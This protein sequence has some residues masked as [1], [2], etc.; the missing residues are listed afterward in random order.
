ML[1]IK[2]TM[3]LGARGV[4][5]AAGSAKSFESAPQMH[6]QVSSRCSKWPPSGLVMGTLDPQVLP[7]SSFGRQMYGFGRQMYGFG[8]QMTPPELPGMT[9]ESLMYGSGREIDG[10]GRQMYC[11]GRQMPPR[12]PPQYSNW[13]LGE[14]M[15]ADSLC[16]G[17]MRGVWGGAWA[18]QN[19]TVL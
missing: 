12:I 7:R 2:K 1:F 8:R 3:L 5:G 9:P 15:C 17:R 19:L 11:F 18:T 16:V 4:R 6:L 14:A 13:D 10:F